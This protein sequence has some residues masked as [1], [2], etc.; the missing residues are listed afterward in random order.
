MVEN[1]DLRLIDKIPKTDKK[2]GVIVIGRGPSV[3]RLDLEQLNKQEKYDICAVS[4]AIKI[5]QHPKFAFNYHFQTIRRTVEYL[6]RA[7]YL[8]VTNNV[9]DKLKQHHRVSNIKVL[10]SLLNVYYFNSRNTKNMDV[11]TEGLF[12]I[13][14]TN[15][16]FSRH[17][18]IGGVMHFL[19]GYMNYRKIYYIGFDGGREYG[20]LFHSNRKETKV[21]GAERD[22]ALSWETVMEMVKHYDMEVFGP[23]KEFLM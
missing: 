21:K 22:Y 5:T 23:L 9:L 12:D 20:K 19:L 13:E 11:F 6:Y 14:V 1:K 10:E 16:L 4:D 18:S 8:I 3:D 2:E 15:K 17:G 7:E